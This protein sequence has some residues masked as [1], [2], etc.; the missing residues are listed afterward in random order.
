MFLDFF[1]DLAYIA[2]R[3]SIQRSIISLASTSFVDFL[4]MF[5][6]VSYSIVEINIMYEY[7]LTSVNEDFHDR[8]ASRES[9]ADLRADQ[10][11]K[12]YRRRRLF[13]MIGCSTAAIVWIFAIIITL[14]VIMK[15]SEDCHPMVRQPGEVSS[16]GLFEAF[17]GAESRSY[18]GVCEDLLPSGVFCLVWQ[19]NL[20][21]TP[22]WGCA[23]AEFRPRLHTDGNCTGLAE[24][25]HALL[26]LNN[27]VSHLENIRYLHIGSLDDQKCLLTDEN[28]PR[29]PPG[30]QSD[31]E[32]I[33]TWTNLR[34]MSFGLY[35]FDSLP[36]SWTNLSEMVQINIED[37]RMKTIDVDVLKAMAKL[38]RFDG[39]VSPHLKN[40]DAFEELGES[41]RLNFVRFV[42]VD[43]CSALKESIEVRCISKFGHEQQTCG[44]ASYVE[45]WFLQNEIDK[46]RRTL[47]NDCQDVCIERL[48][49]FSFLDIDNTGRVWANE[50]ELRSLLQRRD[51][52]DYP[53]IKFNATAQMTQE[54]AALIGNEGFLDP[55]AVQP[56]A[57]VFVDRI[58]PNQTKPI[59]AA[60]VYT[61]HG[62]GS[63]LTID[64]FPED[65]S[66]T[67]GSAVTSVSVFEFSILHP[68]ND[69]SCFTSVLKSEFRELSNTI[70]GAKQDD[71]RELDISFGMYFP[72]SGSS[73]CQN[74]S[75]YDAVV[76]ARNRVRQDHRQFRQV[77]RQPGV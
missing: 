61:V 54:Q 7:M 58:Y 71:L 2:V 33:S 27:T 19:F 41:S 43:E 76:E 65:S 40:F 8:I 38:E 16:D 73:T 67:F 70:P 17:S 52:L 68:G 42:G 34:S 6:I 48:N 3:V 57:K 39:G 15:A 21:L 14:K 36:K 53:L 10:L 30:A 60:W 12:E 25:N 32:L 4:G 63:D 37:N 13:T 56:G 24:N 35:P 77:H 22:G 66:R 72:L 75:F 18:G 59:G 23:F 28:D 47:T 74:C 1:L 55:L 20:F 44:G 46:L 29:L 50:L 9:M 51:V 31:A 5:A 62:T 49:D 64:A 11:A 69:W 45:E 26:Q